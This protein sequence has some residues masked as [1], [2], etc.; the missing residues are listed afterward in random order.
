MAVIEL[1]SFSYGIGN[2]VIGKFE[3]IEDTEFSFHSSGD[4]RSIDLVARDR[5]Q[6]QSLLHMFGQDL[7][8]LTCGGLQPTGAGQEVQVPGQAFAGLAKQI[9]RSRCEEGLFNADLVETMLE[10]FRNLGRLQRRQLGVDSDPGVDGPLATKPQAGQE[11]SVPQED[12]TKER[13][14]REV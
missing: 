5:N 7:F 12:Q 13:G 10:E 8:G 4:S 2:E 9:H 3:F 1:G 6:A 14:T 11:I